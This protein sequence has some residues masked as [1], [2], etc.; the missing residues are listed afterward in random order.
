MEIEAS[1][2][3][4]IKLLGEHAVVYG[5]LSLAMAINI[6]ATAHA[7]DSS[8]FLIELADIG[9]KKKFSIDELNK[10]YRS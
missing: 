8:G 1:A 3:G 5:K 9:E 4:V 2:P 7:E 10:L 6:Y